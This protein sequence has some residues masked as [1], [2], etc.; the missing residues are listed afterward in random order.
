MVA[1]IALNAPDSTKQTAEQ[2]SVPAA[3]TPPSSPAPASSS[4]ASR[5][6]SATR[7]A[8][9]PGPSLSL[10]SS[11]QDGSGTAK[12]LPLVVLNNT[13][14][15]GLATQAAD[16]FRSGGWTVTDIGNLSNT[17]I[18]T[19]AYYDPDVDGAEAAAKALRKQFPSI[20]RVTSKFPEL[21]AGPIVVVL[22]P[23]YNGG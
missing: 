5:P 14:T 2:R 23:D 19:C 6:P 1:V 22:T 18:S 8:S 16:S 12:R 10:G 13:T 9:G 17:I 7:T 15:S 21:P 11:S 4:P 3:S 20:K